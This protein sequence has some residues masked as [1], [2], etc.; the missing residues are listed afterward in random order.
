MLK[1]ILLSCCILWSTHRL[2]KL[3]SFTYFFLSSAY[4]I[5][6]T[7][8]IG[9]VHDYSATQR[10]QICGLWH[11]DIWWRELIEIFVK[12]LITVI[13]VEKMSINNFW[14]FKL[15]EVSNLYSKLCFI[16][17]ISEF[18]YYFFSYSYT[19]KQGNSKFNGS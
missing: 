14:L 8:S 3:Y 19:E 18:V 12:Y 10:T 5:K 4:I 17:V 6:Y 2:W 13:W 16:L 9:T 1:N 11:F 15:R 7:F